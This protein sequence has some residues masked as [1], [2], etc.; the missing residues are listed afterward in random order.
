MNNNV[1]LD[2][3]WFKFGVPISILSEVFN[4][5][6]SK[7]KADFVWCKKTGRI[8]LETKIPTS[9]LQNLAQVYQIFQNERFGKKAGLRQ[10]AYQ[11]IFNKLPH[12]VPD[13]VNMF[14][15]ITQVHRVVTEGYEALVNAIFGEKGLPNI[16]NV[17]QQEFELVLSE[18]L[19]PQSPAKLDQ[20]IASRIMTKLLNGE[21]ATT[22]NSLEKQIV[23]EA[24][25]TLTPREEKVVQM[26][27]GLN[28]PQLTLDQ[29]AAHFGITRER[30]R[31]IE[32]RSLRKLRYPTRSRKMKDFFLP[33]HERYESLTKQYQSMASTWT[34]PE[35]PHE[36]VSEQEMVEIPSQIPE[37]ESINLDTSIDE[38]EISVRAYNVLKN[39]D[40]R[41]VRDLMALTEKD[42]LRF[43]YSGKKTLTEL[44]DLLS[45]LGLSFTPMS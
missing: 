18:G 41:S 11:A 2:C 19:L 4:R 17:V 35:L 21:Y 3:E 15:E 38:L 10:A 16:Y 6:E 27:F 39:A 34:R 26:H 29:I 25:N 14:S 22:L 20:L 24:L 40:V 37:T 33:L 1:P 7:I 9:S 43:R 23:D 31:Q 36:E 32:L 30:I 12:L 45:G 8:P 44:K 5:T 28:G 13:L 42:F